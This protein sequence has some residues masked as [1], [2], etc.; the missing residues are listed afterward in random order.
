M[1]VIQDGYSDVPAGKIASVVT[2]LEMRRPAPP[3]SAPPS[4]GVTMRRVHA[5]DVNWY[6]ELYRRIGRDWL[7][8]SM[9]EKPRGEVEATIADEA[10]EIYTLSREDT[11][12]QDGTDEALL[13][14]DFRTAEACEL[15]F[16]GVTD[17]LIGMGAGRHLMNK[18]IEFAWSRPI[19]RFWVHT[20]TLDHPSALSFYVRS[21]FTPYK[22]QIELVDDP[23]LTG[24]LDA[25]AAPHVPII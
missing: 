21:G 13:E 22:R 8:F 4:I 19:K 18:A 1:S 25:D 14:L 9:L 10:V 20:C 15:A 12:R 11:D 5:P 7:W 17:A 24:T 3:R 2:H 6:L 16:F 23:R